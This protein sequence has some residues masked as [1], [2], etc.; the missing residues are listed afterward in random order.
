MISS[1]LDRAR[2][3]VKVRDDIHS[4][5]VPAPIT[6]DALRSVVLSHWTSFSSLIYLLLFR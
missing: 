6:P 1:W 2:E 4:H 5:V 3:H